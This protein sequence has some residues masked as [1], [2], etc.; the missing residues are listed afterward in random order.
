MSE[1]LTIEVAFAIREEQRLIEIEVAAGTSAA[2]AVAQSAVLQG[3]DVDRAT[4]RLGI[5][6]NPVDDD[7]TLREGDRLE[8]YRPLTIEPKEARRL[9]AVRDSARVPGRGGSR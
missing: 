8:I 1:R 4:L 3:F 2:D 5:W 9:R 7:Y 6:G